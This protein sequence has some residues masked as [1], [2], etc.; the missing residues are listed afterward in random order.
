VF[1]RLLIASHLFTMNKGFKIF[2]FILLTLVLFY[3]IRL[4]TYEPEPQC[5]LNFVGIIDEFD[6]L[7]VK[8]I[9]RF[10]SDSAVTGIEINIFGH[11]DG[12]GLILIGK[13]DSSSIYNYKLDSGEIDFEYTNDWQSKICYVSF[14]PSEHS[15]GEMDINVLFK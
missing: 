4:L 8:N 14:T 2:L 5:E 15:T 10:K 12:E 9:A 11:I 7:S 6:D 3:S 1:G 13:N